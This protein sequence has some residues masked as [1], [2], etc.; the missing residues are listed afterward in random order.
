MN[1]AWVGVEVRHLAALDAIDS[2]RSYRGAAE[3]LGYVQSSVSQQ[4]STLERLV[5]ARLVERSTGQSVIGL[6]HAGELLLRH[7]HRILGTLTAAQADLDALTNRGAS[8]VRVGAFQSAAARILPGALAS[9][10]TASPDVRVDVAE[11][12][13]DDELFDA[14][15][16]GE[17]D[18]A[19]AELP[20]VPGPFQAVELTVDPCVLLVHAE[21]PLA[22]RELAPSL[23]EIAQL[24]LAYPKWRM[25]HLIDQHFRA[26]GLRPMQTFALSTNAAVQALVSTGE[27][28]AI[29]PRLAVDPTVVETTAIDL[30]SR[31]PSRTLVLFWHAERIYGS[32][33]TAFVEAARTVCRELAGATATRRTPGTPFTKPPEGHDPR[34]ATGHEPRE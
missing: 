21:S 4:I 11:T 12:P 28:A 24:P 3:R 29:M 19:F 9:L 17:V 15:A 30:D 22:Q 32:A 8:S 20:L 18:C 7:A 34:L 16:G 10:A 14:V 13:S 6:T 27:V 23:E 31:L 25:T 1:Q 5:G 26:A 33:L 2:E